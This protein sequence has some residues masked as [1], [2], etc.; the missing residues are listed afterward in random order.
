[1]TT[2]ISVMYGSEKVKPF[3]YSSGMLHN[4]LVTSAKPPA[5]ITHFCTGERLLNSF[6]TTLAIKSALFL[7][8]HRKHCQS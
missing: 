8:S 6:V 5:V 3:K 7:W 1:M 4:V 2:E